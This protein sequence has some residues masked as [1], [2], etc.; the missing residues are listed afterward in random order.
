MNNKK[1]RIIIL[2]GAMAIAC[3]IATYFWAQSLSLDNQNRYHLTQVCE[4]ERQIALLRDFDK[5]LSHQQA[6]G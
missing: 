6:M 2:A 4:L 1:H 5:G 3:T